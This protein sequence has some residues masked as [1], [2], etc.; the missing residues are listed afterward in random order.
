[1]SLLP[2]LLGHPDDLDALVAWC[3]EQERWPDEQARE[4]FCR[5]RGWRR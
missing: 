3:E 5:E 1:M 4:A 2:W